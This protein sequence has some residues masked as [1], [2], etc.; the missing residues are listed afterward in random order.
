MV[1]S[2]KFNACVFELDEARMEKWINK[3][4]RKFSSC[5]NEYIDLINSMD[6]PLNMKIDSCLYQQGAN[7]K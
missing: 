3:M 5:W 2:Y 6:N 1:M 4:G 7:H